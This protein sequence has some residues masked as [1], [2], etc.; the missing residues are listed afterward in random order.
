MSRV[1]AGFVAGPA[2]KLSIS[3]FLPEQQC[4]PVHWMIHVPAFAEEMNKSRAMIS[5]HARQLADAGIAVVVP[6]LYGTG[7]SE[8]EFNQ[9]HWKHWKNDLDYLIQW[10]Q[11]QGAGTITLWGLR[12]GCLL[13]LDLVQEERRIVC[14]LLLWQ[15]VLSGKLHLGQFFAPADGFCNDERCN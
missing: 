8:G 6:D 12:L 11:G 13:A 10:A 3:V 7:D 9:A 14:G 2:G 1:H 4:I 15:P 5:V